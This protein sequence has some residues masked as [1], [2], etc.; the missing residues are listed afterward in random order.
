[1]AKES[2]LGAGLLVAGYDY[3]GDI[4]AV[5]SI[6]GGPKLTEAVTGIDKLAMERIGLQRDGHMDITNWF[7]PAANMSH[8]RLGLLPTTDVQVQYWH[9]Q[10]I[11]RPVACCVAKQANYDPTRAQDG[12]FTMETQFMANGFGLE[13]CTGLTAFKRTDTTATAGTAVDMTTPAFTG[14]STFGLQ[15]YL[16]VFAFTGTSATI[17]IQESSDNGA[18]AY[19]NVVGGG[20]TTVT[21]ITHERIQ[22]SRTLTVERYL[23]VTTTGTFSN[24]IFSVAVARNDT[25]T[26]F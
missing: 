17:T 14:S 20:F 25:L 22:T 3:T 23:K 24:L 5:N 4:T 9:R 12:S 15:A 19:A 8:K 6:S 16:Q 10:V 1:M 2:G 26:A 11:A 13:W 21:G 18:D 7:N